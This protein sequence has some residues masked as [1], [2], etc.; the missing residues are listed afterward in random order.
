MAGA[1]AL[2]NRFITYGGSASTI[3]NDIR[4]LDSDDDYIWKI[5]KPDVDL[6]DFPGR[7]GHSMCVFERYLVIFGGCGPYSNKLKKRSRFQD[8]ICFD[9]ETGKYCKFD[10]GQNDVHHMRQ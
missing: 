4:C 8:T 2:G 7:F 10:G 6:P 1:V 9:T 5:L 3:L